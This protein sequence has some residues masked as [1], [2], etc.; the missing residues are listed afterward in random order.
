MR[1]FFT[2]LYSTAFF[3]SGYAQTITDHPLKKINR[4]V[5]AMEFVVF[6]TDNSNSS[7]SPTKVTLGHYVRDS[8]LSANVRIFQ[9]HSYTNTTANNTTGSKSVNVITLDM[10]GDS[11]DEIVTAREKGNQVILS[12]PQVQ[13]NPLST[14]SD[15]PGEAINLGTIPSGAAPQIKMAKGDF[16][17]NG[18]EY[19]A[20]ATPEFTL[21]KIS[22]DIFFYDSIAG[23]PSFCGHINAD[24]LYF[25]G[26]NRPVGNLDIAINDF[27]GDSIPDIALAAFEKE[28]G[29]FRCYVKTFKVTPAPTDAY[30]NWTITAMG[31]QTVTS[32]GSNST[33]ENLAISSGIYDSTAA[34]KKQIAVAVAYVD[35][36]DNTLLHRKLFIASTASGAN[37]LNTVTVSANNYVSDQ[38]NFNDF[39]AVAIVSGDFNSDANEEIVLAFDNALRVYS[40][41]NNLV[42]TPKASGSGGGITTGFNQ[43]A[44]NNS[45]LY[46]GDVDLDL[47]N[48]VLI[49]TSHDDQNSQQYLTV[50]VLGVNPSLNTATVKGSKNNLQQA[51]FSGFGSNYRFAA[52]FGEFNGG[53]GILKA[54]VKSIRKIL[55]PIVVNNSPPY[56]YDILGTDTADLTSCFPGSGFQ[57]NQNSQ[58]KAVN[59][60]SSTV[61]TE[62]K[63]DWGV[64]GTLSAGGSVMGV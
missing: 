15:G 1:N 56:H 61:E 5:Q 47:E 21:K 23:Y 4:P 55:T 50:T 19:F 60:Q 53:R 35:R 6:H 18:K 30:L 8:G 48:D 57:C 14:V 42:I 58:Y 41:G 33:L 52:A 45:Y 24:S 17:R 29:G 64:S 2:I 51:N 32:V 3:V 20:I 46:I 28:S 54:P 12:M 11:Y 9:D 7:N 40:I 25:D 43:L 34:P 26:S 62:L 63:S 37:G 36:N 27:N 44:P 13:R 16:R 31:K 59:Q 10:N 39:P 22:I 38:S 49:V